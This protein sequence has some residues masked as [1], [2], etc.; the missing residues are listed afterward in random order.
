MILILLGFLPSMACAAA[1]PTAA[2]RAKY[3]AVKQKL[4][5]DLQKFANNDPTVDADTLAQDRKDLADA[6]AALITLDLAN[7]AISDMP[8]DYGCLN[9]RG[10]YD[11]ACFVSGV[12]AIPFRAELSGKHDI[13][14]GISGDVFAGVNLRPFRSDFTFTPF[15]YVGYLPTLANTQSTSSTTSGATQSSGTSSNGM[16]N[17][18]LDVGVG[19]AV[20]LNTGFD[21]TSNTH[22]HIGVVV[23]SDITG[24]TQYAY[25]SKLYAS[26]LIG[27]NF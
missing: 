22:A 17:G 15:I 10:I 26:I 21:P 4:S 18:A 9:I 25:N 19:L 20:P 16:S 24:S 12:I 1:N 5:Q 27:F 7:N 2:A 11:G 6:Q 14:P 8:A 3:T 23:G 13:Y